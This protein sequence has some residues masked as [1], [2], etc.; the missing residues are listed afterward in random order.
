MKRAVALCAILAAAVPTAWAGT[1]SDASFFSSLTHT[2][3]DFE[4][5]GSGYA[6]SHM[7]TL[8]SDEYTALGV[9]FSDDLTYIDETET[10]FEAAQA[11][12]GSLEMSIPSPSEDAF[13]IIFSTQVRAVGFW[14]V[15]NNTVTEIPTFVA[16][17][18]SG[19]TIDTVTFTGGLI[20]GTIGIA[21]YGFMGIWATEDIAQLDV[22]KDATLLDDL[23]FS[24]TPEPA[25]LAVLAIG[26]ALL[27]RRR[28]R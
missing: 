16:K 23:T 11:I 27:V 17:N 4:T 6:T 7:Q 2:V 28:N 15:N 10:Y 1:I 20:D 14:V 25:T 22:T 19:G 8:W 3:I 26:A 12:G 18:S 9:D 24:P 13:S 5:D 21:D